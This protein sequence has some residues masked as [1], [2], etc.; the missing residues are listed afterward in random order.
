MTYL[1][2]IETTVSIKVSERASLRAAGTPLSKFQ[3]RR[4]GNGSVANQSS[5][6]VKNGLL[7]I[8]LNR[9]FCNYDRVIKKIACVKDR[10]LEKSTPDVL[11]K[12][13]VWFAKDSLSIAEKCSILISSAS[14][15]SVRSEI[16]RKLIVF[17]PQEWERGSPLII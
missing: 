2:I 1:K 15:R 4:N 17:S 8:L 3:R 6:V 10:F 13:I 9:V 14:D 12:W 11:H 16:Q 5:I 7:K